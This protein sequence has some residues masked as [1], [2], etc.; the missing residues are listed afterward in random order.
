MAE[1]ALSGEEGVCKGWDTIA[2]QVSVAKHPDFKTNTGALLH[3]GF[4]P[5]V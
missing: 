4:D 2:T 5:D 1:M 3:V